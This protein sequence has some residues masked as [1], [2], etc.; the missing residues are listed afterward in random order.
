MEKTM[1]DAYGDKVTVDFD[2]KF[3]RLKKAYNDTLRSAEICKPSDRHIYVS[4]A[5]GL[6]YRCKL[7]FEDF[8]FDSDKETIIKALRQ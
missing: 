6:L 8:G 2:S 1:T 7:L 5:R 4:A 3:E